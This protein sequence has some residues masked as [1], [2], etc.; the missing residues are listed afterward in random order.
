MQ[1]TNRT[2]ASSQ[3]DGFTLV[4]LMVVCAI[5]AV[6]MGMGAGALSRVGL[7]SALDGGDRMVRSALA[8]ARSTARD[9]AAL[10][11]VAIVPATATHDARIAMALT[12]DAGTWHFDHS[13]GALLMAGHNNVSRL[14]GAS[15]EPGG[16]VRSCA[17]LNGG[18]VVCGDSPYY[19]PVRGFAVEMD[20]AP[21]ADDR[22]RIRAGT[23]A[24]FGQA[25]SLEI[26]E[27]GGLRAQVTLQPQGEVVE[28]KTIPGLFAPWRWARVGLTWDGLDLT[29]YA[30]NVLVAAKSALPNLLVPPGRD[31]HLTFGGGGFE[32]RIDEVVYRTVDEEQVEELDGAVEIPLQAPLLVRFDAD[33]RLDPRIHDAE[34]VIPIEVEGERRE[35]HIDLSGVVR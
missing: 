19:D 14:S 34:V 6:L 32:G 1:E 31:A 8:R 25:F 9:Q 29:V 7:S 3:A 23:L 33:G 15:L 11:S 24:S 5:M 26:T 35:V 16:T 2:H 10:S 18:S 12:R 13:D 21:D 22:G 30:H 28:V 27:E 4:E 20:V 17:R